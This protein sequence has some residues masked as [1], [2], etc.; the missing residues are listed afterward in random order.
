M[1][2]I[3]VST[4]DNLNLVLRRKGTTEP[5]TFKGR[6]EANRFA[7]KHLMPILDKNIQDWYYVKVK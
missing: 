2:H 4:K 3:I 1:L 6:I 7:A 5:L